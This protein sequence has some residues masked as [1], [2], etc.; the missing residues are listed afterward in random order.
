M[1]VK[2]GSA[3]VDHAIQSVLCEL[4]DDDELVIINDGSVDDTCAKLDQYRGPHNSSR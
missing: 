1:P 4:S 3:S 2:D